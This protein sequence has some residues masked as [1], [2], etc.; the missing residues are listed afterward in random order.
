MGPQA[1][2]S[3]EAKVGLEFHVRLDLD[4]KLFAPSPGGREPNQ[5]VSAHCLGLPGTLPL[6]HPGALDL[7]LRLALGLGATPAKR[8]RFARKHYN[9]PDLPK[10][11]QISQLEPLAEGGT[12]RWPNGELPLR[13]LHLEEDAGRS[14]R[15]PSGRLGIDMNR[16]GAAL[17][18]IVSAPT[19]GGGA[20]AGEAF[21]WLRALVVALGVSRGALQDGDIRCDANVSIG[22]GPRCEIKNL[23]SYRFV[24]Q[25]VEAEIER[26]RAAD[27]PV[28]PTTLGFDRKQRRTVP[29]RSKESRPEYRFLPEPDLPSYRVPSPP[30]LET[31]CPMETWDRLKAAG[32]PEDT[33]RF[34][35]LQPSW[36][37]HLAPFR[38]SELAA[39]AKLLAHLGA[40]LA[41]KAPE[42]EDT[43]RERPERIRAAVRAARAG[44]SSV[45]QER[46]LL[47]KGASAIDPTT[48]AEAVA[49]D[50]PGVLAKLREGH[51]KVLGYLVGQAMRVAP[52]CDPLR[53]RRCFEIIACRR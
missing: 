24:T 53:L 16:S 51:P 28:R 27:G 41:R 12:L 23:N 31:A 52:G 47:G 18:E 11:Y 45:E 44:K 22:G 8:C 21:R 10:G 30:P 42:L 5:D 26:Q 43:W 33:A 37:P 3:A 19:L 7:A 25:A 35:A 36:T 14:K 49:M 40:G 4:G 9:Y 32:C 39:A 34:F 38:G 48:V 20:E 2:V 17:V 50:H 13:S 46:L 15:L 29:M 1:S 6:P